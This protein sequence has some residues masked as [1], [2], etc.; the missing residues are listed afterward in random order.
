M[1]RNGYGAKG[2]VIGF[3]VIEKVIGK[4]IGFAVIASRH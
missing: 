4:V 3:A 2:R 1:G